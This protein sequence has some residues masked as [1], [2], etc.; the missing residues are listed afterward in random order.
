MTDAALLSSRAVIRVAGPDARPFLSNV[1]TQDVAGLAPDAAAFAALL[2][3]QGKILADFILLGEQDG[4][5]LDVAAAA[6]GSLVKRLSLYRLRARATIEPLD[7]WAVG[8]VWNGE[9]GPAPEGVRR[10]ADPRLP[11]L[12]AR[13]IGPKAALAEALG[14]EA[15]D[16]AAYDRHRLAR[17]VPE[18]DRDFGPEELFLLDVGYDALNGVSYK[19][20]C[21]VG[22]EVS[23]RMKRKGEVRKRTLQVFFDG[24]PPA[25]GAP[26]TGGGSAIGEML[27][28]ADGAGLALIRLDRLAAARAAGEP[29]GVE[30]RPVE[31]RFPDWLQQG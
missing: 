6:A 2:T 27:S 18:F 21:F 10:F 8:A 16:E 23:S 4:V 29:L 14:P 3:P 9:T 20:G 11:T 1:V 7:G 31:I 12:G 25:K 26:V 30:G 15:Q 5:L 22:Q 19:K 24:P 13:L 17:G 28:A